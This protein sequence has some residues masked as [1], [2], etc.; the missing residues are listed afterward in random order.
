MSAPPASAMKQYQPSAAM[1]A[2]VSG[3]VAYAVGDGFNVYTWYCTRGATT[4][5]SSPP[6]TPRTALPASMTTTASN[7]RP[8]PGPGCVSAMRGDAGPPGGGGILLSAIA[9]LQGTGRNRRA[10]Y[11]PGQLHDHY[12][13]PRRAAGSGSGP[14]RNSIRR[15]SSGT[16]ATR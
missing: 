5:Q 6:P 8:G 14:K 7:A 15:L 13:F 1:K 9:S 4:A 2:L 11:R 10:G 12:R 3:L 16:L